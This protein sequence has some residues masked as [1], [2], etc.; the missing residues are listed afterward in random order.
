[1]LEF[2]TV[3]RIW[4]SGGWNLQLLRGPGHPEVG[5]CDSCE[6]LGFDCTCISADSELRTPV[7]KIEEPVD[8]QLQLKHTIA[9]ASDMNV[10]DRN[11]EAEEE[12]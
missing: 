11:K 9:W 3:A 2:A 1:M 12:A 4:A 10:K 5:I 8:P 7:I 6:D